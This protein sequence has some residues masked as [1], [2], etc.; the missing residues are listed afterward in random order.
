MP[1]TADPAS[2]EREQVQR[3]G[4][5]R[6]SAVAVSL[7]LYCCLLELFVVV[8]VCSIAVEWVLKIYSVW[9]HSVYLLE[10]IL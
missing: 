10:Y 7:L 1:V 2:A 9:D 6:V 3:V 4:I 8:V 5:V